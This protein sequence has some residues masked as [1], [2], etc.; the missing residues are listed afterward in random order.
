MDTPKIIKVLER[1]AAD[2][3][4]RIGSELNKTH[5][6]WFGITVLVIGGGMTLLWIWVMLWSLGYMIG[7]W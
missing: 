4:Q 6:N 5:T 7:F 1:D 3:I 2:A